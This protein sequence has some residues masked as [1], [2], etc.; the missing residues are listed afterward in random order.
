MVVRK[1]TRSMMRNQ[2]GNKADAILKKLRAML[3]QG[4]SH[5]AIEKMIA[6]ELKQYEGATIAAASRSVH[7]ILG[8]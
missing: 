6:K 3:N 1:D 2:L 8:T 5:K 7:V 4:A